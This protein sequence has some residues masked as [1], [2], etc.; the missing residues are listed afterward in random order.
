[1]KSKWKRYAIDGEIKR[2]LEETACYDPRLLL[3]ELKV[4]LMDL[5]RDVTTEMHATM[6][7]ANIT[8][9]STAVGP[10]SLTRRCRTFLIRALI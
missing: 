4:P 6:I 3:T 9:Y 5:P 7:K 1:M 10:S 2:S 8:A